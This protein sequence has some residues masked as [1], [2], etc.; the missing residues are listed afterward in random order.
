MSED[1]E[2]SV[3]LQNRQSSQ[4]EMDLLTEDEESIIICRNVH[5]TY[6]L[7]LEG[8]PA[9]R[10][11]SVTIR[12]GEFIVILGKSGGGKTSMLN[13]FGTI[14]R[15]TKGELTICHQHIRESTTD[16]EFANLRLHKIGFVFQT[17]NLIGSMT[18]IENVGLPMTLA[19]TMS[20]FQIQSRAKMLLTRVG[21]G[22]RLT[23]LPSQLSGG[24]Q[25]RVTIARALAN[26]PELLLLD[27]P[28]GSR[29]LIF[30]P[31]V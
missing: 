28:T 22:A 5:K 12:R 11:V 25:Q 21:M 1:K 13:I 9:L 20:P 4:V 19:G 30:H 16:E 3:S 18:A 31:D 14:D 2:D 7:G 6:L 23:H 15:P 24:E 29:D 10:G 17:F 27:E 26:D 8:V